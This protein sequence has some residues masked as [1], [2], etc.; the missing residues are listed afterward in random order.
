MSIDHR[1]RKHADYQ[2]VYAAGRKQFG[3][4]MN[5]FYVLRCAHA[6]KTDA[7]GD[8][9]RP[10]ARVGLT[11]G[12]VLGKSVDRSRIKRRLREA[13]RAQLS[14]LSA[15]VDV[16]LHPRRAVIDLDFAIL[17]RE[18]ASTFLTI[19]RAVEKQMA[20]APVCR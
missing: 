17:Q 13:V 1:L 9:S 12:K 16:V 11:V 7:C 5:Y 15:P 6:D 8:S 14:L 19:Q 10:V 18:I 3:R 4:Q 2:H 20:S